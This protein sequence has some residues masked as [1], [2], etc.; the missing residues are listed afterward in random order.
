MDAC[1]IVNGPGFFDYKAN[2]GRLIVDLYNFL[3]KH[4]AAAMGQQ[5]FQG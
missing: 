2:L 3:Y 1:I 5:I 4:H